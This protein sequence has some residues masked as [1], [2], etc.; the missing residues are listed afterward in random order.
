MKKLYSLFLSLTVL[1]VY[2]QIILNQSESSARTV[3]D[4][5]VVVLAQGFHA[6]SSVSNPFVAKIGASTETPINNPINSDA[7]ST[8]P[9]G[10]TDTETNRFHDTQGNIEV[11]GGGQLQFTLPI[12]LP[13]GV[14]SVA[15]Q[16]NLVYTSGSGNGIAGYGWNISGITAISRTGRTIEKDGEIRG[17]Q[18]NYSDY[19]S[20]N[21]QRLIYRGGG[22]GPD[23][24]GADGSIYTTEKFSNIKVKAVGTILGQSWQGPEYWEVTFE[25][26]SQAWY[27]AITTGVSNARTPV[28]YNIVK[29]KDA[30]GNY[31]SYNYVQANNVALISSIHWGGNESLGKDHFNSITFNYITRDLR[32]TSYN[33]GLQFVQDKLLINTT[34]TSNG[35]QFKKYVITYAKDIVNNDS[36]HIINYQFVRSIQ[37][38]NSQNQASNPVTFTTKPL[39]TTTQEK[40]FGN[41]ENIIA[42]GD[43]NG[44]GLVDFI[45]KQ[46]TQNGR[47]E[48]YYLYFDAINSANSS[49]VYLGSSSNF[50]SQYILTYNIK[51]SDGYIKPKQGLLIAKSNSTSYTIPPATGT[52]ELKYYSVNSDAS[53]LN[54]TNNPL[55]LEYSKI[56]NPEDYVYMD[57]QYPSAPSPANYG[58]ANLSQLE[59]PKE[60]DIDSDGIS[61]LIF[62]VKDSK[63]YKS[64]ISPYNWS[65]IDLGYRYAVVN[66]AEIQNSNIH[67]LNNITSKNILNKGSIMDFDNDGKQDILFIEPNIGNVNVSF[68]TRES[69][70]GNIT[71]KSIS[72]QSNRISQYYLISTGSSYSMA[73]KNTFNVKGLDK[74]IQFADLN[75]DRNIEILAPLEKGD[76]YSTYDMGWSIN[77]N[78]GKTLSESFQGLVLFRDDTSYTYGTQENDYPTTFDIDNDGKSEFVMFINNYSVNLDRSYV[79]IANIREFQYNPN[80]SQFKWSYKKYFDNTQNIGGQVL[81]PIYGDFRVNNNN[82]KILLI[83]KSTN[84]AVS[85]IISYN[86]YNLTN[87]KNITAIT[88]GGINTYI[89]YKEL[90]PSVNLNFYSPV[91]TEQYPYVEL[92]KISQSYAV[93]QLRQTSADNIRKQD[94]RYRG[95][96]THLQGKGMIG[97]R[98]T[99]RSSWYTDDLVNTKIWSGAEIDPLNEGVPIKE[100]SIKTNTESQI[101]PADISENNTQLLSFKQTTYR[102]DISGVVKA[103]VPIKS[104]SKDFIK[105]VT[106]INTITYDA[107]IPGSTKYYLPVQ[108]VTNI[109]N[110]F[111]IST[112]DLSYIHNPSGTGKDYYIGRPASKTDKMTV[113][114]DSKGAKESYTYENNLLKTK[115]SWNRNNKGYFLETYDYDGFGNVKERKLQRAILLAIEANSKTEKAEYDPKGRFVIKKTD[116]LGLETLITYNDWGQVLTQT[117]PLDVVLTNTY[118]GWG[119][120]LTSKINLSGT[121]TYQYKKESNGDTVIIEYSPD[122]DQKFSYTNKYGQNYLNKTKKFGQGQYISVKTSFDPLGRKSGESEPYSGSSP[123]HWNTISYDEYSRPVKASGFTG[124]IVETSYNGRTVTITETNA[125]NRFK[126]QTADPLG[127]IISSEDLGGTITFKYNAAGENTEANYEGNIVKTTYDIWGNKARFEDPSN[128]IYEYEYNGFMGAISKTKSP[129]GEKTY[130]Y[131]NKGQLQTQTEKTTSGNATDKTINFTYNSKGLITGKSGTSLGKAYSSGI[132]YDTFGR[133]LSSYED[134]NGKYFIKKGITYDDKMR[135]ASYEKQLYSSGILTKVS[136][137]NEYEAWNGELYRVKEKGTGKILWQLNEVNDKG[138]VTKTRLGGVNIENNY[139]GNG[140]L[141][142][143]DHKSINTGNTVLYVD[144]S[145]DAIKNE[146]NSRFRG[147]DFSISESFQYDDNNRLYNWT[148]PVTGTFTQNQ[149]RNV[150]DNKG[151][152]TQNDQVGTFSF[153]NAQKKYQPTAMMLNAAG[154]ANYTNDLLQKISYNEN[155]DPVFINGVRGDVRFEYGL[156]SMRQKV[157]YGGNF[158][159]E[160]DGKFTKYYSED[161]SYEVIR[162]N[163]TGQEKHL[164]YIGGTPYESNIVYLKN[165]SQSTGTYHFLHK[166]YLGSILAITND[167]G[168]AIEQ[169]HYDAWGNFTNLKIAGATVDP[170]NVGNYEFLVDR[171]YTSHEH[172]AEVG[173]IHMNGRLYDPL[174]RRFLNADENIQDAFNTQN[175]NKYGYVLNNPL[176]FSDPSGEFAFLP[177]ITAFIISASQAVVVSTIMYMAQAIITGNGSNVG[178]LKTIFNAAIKAGLFGGYGNVFSS[179][180]ATASFLVNQFLPEF[181]W[182]PTIFGQK[183]FVSPSFAFG[184]GI[185]IGA[186]IS[187]TFHMGDFSLDAGFGIMNYGA[188]AGSGASG[189]EYRKSAMFSYSSKA[190]SFSLGTNK[191]SGLHKQQTG[192]IGLGSGDFSLTYENDGSPFD[193]KPVAGGIL[194]DG[195]DRWRTAAMTINIGDFHAGFNLFTG[196]RK[197]ESYK[198]WDPYMM[199]YTN[200]NG[201]LKTMGG[202]TLPYGFVYEE[203]PRYR[204]GA[205]Y[206]GWGNYRIGIDS[207]RHV[208]HPIQNI[209]AHSWLSPQPGFL[210]LSNRINPY[211]QYQTRN[212][213]TSW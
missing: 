77:L 142:Y 83:S 141:D 23:K 8:N 80:D 192:I 27:G 115:K 48:G 104:I 42:N 52:I 6:T 38:F 181:S 13:P 30:Q 32:E 167:Y 153:S 150:Y 59:S 112:T 159:E 183:F 97:F 168:Y 109:N 20:F 185:G 46:P 206:I 166:D 151:R 88:Q 122:G 201:V 208:R 35:N 7:G 130:T 33:N 126:K 21:G 154:A 24:I 127:N 172:F 146:L 198:D 160:N 34:V 119:K 121:T 118:D 61:E 43:Y 36:N 51:P 65:C 182:R 145:F 100:W 190:F 29:W 45:I 75:G 25:D 207:D 106:T 66:N 163:Q 173:L 128:G 57:Y 213:F 124:K 120:L 12:A 147:G 3:Q 116:N 196:E 203:G 137:E 49:F 135:V 56:I 186:S 86:H 103:I 2:S 107:D 15:P 129:K 102:T 54:T 92:D 67:K 89:E 174:L 91:K 162:N 209:M 202:A 94:F 110:D 171:G 53:V 93:S 74:Y 95:M 176:M 69:Y 79:T 179:W 105:D 70:N 191:W 39:E 178:F 68:Y 134:S 125:N 1:S 114:G 22:N 10:T 138:Q 63:C 64:Q 47:P 188:H 14:K 204:L 136:I 165:Y 144:Y 28:E 155:N 187:T 85:K 58:L 205:A 117:D 99:A 189:W 101:F 132:T 62:G 140:F 16:I 82:S 84:S 194:G 73:L 149:Q 81:Y 78:N 184:Q 113:Y 175:Y 200:K 40:A 210:V 41:F 50:T 17:I 212:K 164:L 148:D 177:L 90:D 169:R 157:T 211:L 161:G 4:P 37:E 156:T 199:D 71:Q 139:T 31:I 170:N 11:N 193:K 55:V 18:L 19:Y 60:I 5:N 9:S 76:Y 158:G 87:D 98:Q 131:N 133:V 96:I 180:Q 197:E 195:N 152:I 26:G 108:T 143:I 123:A 44:D 72:V 111:A